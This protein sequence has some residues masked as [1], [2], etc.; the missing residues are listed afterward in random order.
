MNDKIKPN[1]FKFAENMFCIMLS[2]VC[3][4]VCARKC[5]PEDSIN[6]ESM[7]KYYNMLKYKWYN[8]ETKHCRGCYSMHLCTHEQDL[9]KNLITTP[10]SHKGTTH[11]HN[12]THMY[13]KSNN[14][15]LSPH[16]HCILPHRNPIL[17]PISAQ[18][19][20]HAHTHTNTHTICPCCLIYQIIIHIKSITTWLEDEIEKK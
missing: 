17:N 10:T 4:C 2:W 12:D 13:A 7:L 6:Y 1:L 20:T 18:P 11:T 8:L 5:V 15:T 16:T 14:L 9:K 3:L 19:P